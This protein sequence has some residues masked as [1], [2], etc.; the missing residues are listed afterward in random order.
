[1]M[2]LNPEGYLRFAQADKFLDLAHIARIR[3]AAGA[4]GI[5]QGYGHVIF[6]AD[7]QDLVIVFIEGVFLPCHAHPGKH[8]GT[9]AGNNIH[10]PLVLFDLLNG[11]PGNPAVQGHKVH[12]VL[13][14]QADH[15]NEVLRGQG[16]QVPL[17]VDHAVIHRHGTDHGGAFARKFSSERLGISMRGQVHDRLGAHVDRRHDFLHLD[18][19]VLA[20]L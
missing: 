19:I 9:A 11:L 10:L 4:A 20:V 14:V 8:Q 3:Q 5:P 17:V 13:R 7:V 6:P 1:M 2:R 16:S 12:A 18:V 15:V